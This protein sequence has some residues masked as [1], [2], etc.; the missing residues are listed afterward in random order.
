MVVGGGWGWRSKQAKRCKRYKRDKTVRFGVVGTLI[1]YCTK[2]RVGAGEGWG[3]G[4]GWGG[5]RVKVG[6]GMGVRK[7]WG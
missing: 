5:V 4:K 2:K 7:V 3:D 1:Y 6:V